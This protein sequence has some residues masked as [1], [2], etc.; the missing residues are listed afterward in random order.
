MFCA[1]LFGMNKTIFEWKQIS[2]IELGLI[3]RMGNFN[4]FLDIFSM[5]WAIECDFFSYGKNVFR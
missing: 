2:K 3:L 1:I 4:D 5:P